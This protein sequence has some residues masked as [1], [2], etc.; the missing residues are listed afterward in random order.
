MRTFLTDGLRHF[1][2]A[3][4]GFLAGTGDRIIDRR[5]PA[6]LVV[7]VTIAGRAFGGIADS[8]LPVL[9]AANATVHVYSVPGVIE[10]AGLG[11][12]FSCTS[13]DTAPITVAIEIF[14]SGGGAPLNDA[15]ATARQLPPGNTRT[16]GT[17]DA[18]GV[19][20]HQVTGA[21]PFG[22]VAQG[23]AR[24]VATSKK[25]VCTAYVADVDNS[26]PITS[27][28]LTIIAKLKQKAAN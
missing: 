21:G 10:N 5:L 23:S 6:A 27:W 1:T 25:L 20:V 4:H 2:G 22:S 28:Q 17:S 7:M 9:D 14:D 8:P 16:F 24:I 12:L 15:V 26:P 19:L 18:Q 13:T 3:A 11:T